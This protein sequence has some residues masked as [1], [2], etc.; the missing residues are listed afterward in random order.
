MKTIIILIE[1]KDTKKRATDCHKYG[2]KRESY[3]GLEKIAQKE[4]YS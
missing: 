1:N 4:S 3:R 2:P